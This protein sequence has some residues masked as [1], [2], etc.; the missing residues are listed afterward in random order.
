MIGIFDPCFRC[1]VKLYSGNGHCPLPCC[2]YDYYN[3]LALGKLDIRTIIL[4]EEN[5]TIE[6]IQLITGVRYRGNVAKK[7]KRWRATKRKAG[8]LI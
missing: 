5:K 1:P 7:I 4:W 6:E 2:L 8:L 3:E